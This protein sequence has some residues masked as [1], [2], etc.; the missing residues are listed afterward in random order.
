[1]HDSK[2]GKDYGSKEKLKIWLALFSVETASPSLPL[3]N[4]PMNMKN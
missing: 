4:S 1:M 2:N 3:I